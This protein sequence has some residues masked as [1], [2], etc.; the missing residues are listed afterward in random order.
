MPLSRDVVSDLWVVYRS[1]EASADTV[2][3]VEAFL[4]D[5]PEFEQLI[6]RAEKEE[7]VAPTV[8]PAPEVMMRALNETRRRLRTQRV[9]MG[10]AIFFT[11]VPFSFVFSSERGTG[12][13]VSSRY[14]ADQLPGLPR[15]RRDLV[16]R[17]LRNKPHRATRWA[18]G[19]VAVH[20]VGSR[21]WSA[22][23][24][25]G[26]ESALVGSRT[27]RSARGTGLAD[28]LLTVDQRS[29]MYHRPNALRLRDVLEW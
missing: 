22:R 21:G 9:L 5:D 20:L 2:A 11:L 14:V 4:K 3:L 29:V 7:P 26:R 13:D 8:G 27:V 17:V 6:W 18:V 23:G 24:V 25:G 12:V 16:D 10:L 28:Q 19:Q 15:S 1:G